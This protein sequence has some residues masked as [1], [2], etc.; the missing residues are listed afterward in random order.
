MTAFKPM[1]AGKLESVDQVQY[2]AYATPKIDGI[3]CITTKAGAVSRKLKPIP[4]D[5]IRGMLA[6]LPEGL[7]G[8]LWIP[9]AKNFGEVGACVMSHSWVPSPD[10]LPGFQYL[11]FDTVLQPTMSYLTRC[12]FLASMKLPAW[13]KILQPLRIA[14]LEGLLEYEAE[15]LAKG[16]EGVMLRTPDGGY[17]YGR[18]TVNQGWLVKLKRFDDDEA[19]VVGTEELQHNEN[20]ATQ[21]A[22]GHTKRSTHAAGKVAGGTLGALVLRRP[23]GLVFR[24][25]TG[26][27]AADR[28]EMWERRARL[29]G[30]LAKYRHQGSGAKEAPRFPV[31]LGFRDRADMD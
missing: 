8:E 18:S 14:S 21:D 17:K 15:C 24:C 20:V 6:Q 27:T 22:L 13:V 4:N 25:G 5:F 3:R 26:F 30:R 31:F 23:D 12:A 29:V 11:V 28:A 10:A 1:L 2:P 19:E 9:G 16:Y 7:D